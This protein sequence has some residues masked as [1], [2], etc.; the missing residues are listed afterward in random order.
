MLFCHHIERINRQSD[1]ARLASSLCTC[2]YVLLAIGMFGIFSQ[3]A[4]A[5]TVPGIVDPGRIKQRLDLPETEQPQ[6]RT[7][8]IKAPDI[9]APEEA[10]QIVFRLQELNFKGVSVYKKQELLPFYQQY[11]GEKI[12]LKVIYNVIDEI[13][14]H[15]KRDGYALVS[16][17]I[18]DQDF[19][20]GIIDV[21]IVEGYVSEVI[22][23]QSLADTDDG[24]L[25]KQHA[26]VITQERPL[27][28]DTLQRHLLLTNDI[29]GLRVDGA[30]QPARRTPGA[31]DIKVDA[32]RDSFE[33]F[34]SIDN[35]GPE[36]LG[37]VQFQVG[38]EYHSLF[39][40]GDTSQIKLGGTPDLDTLRY[41]FLNHSHI[42][43]ASGLRLGADL[44]Y[45]ETRPDIAGLEGLEGEA[46]IASLNSRYPIM[47]SMHRNVFV[48][49]SFDYLD[50]NNAFLEREL[51]SDGL[52]SLRTG[53]FYSQR[54]SWGGDNIVNVSI[55]QGLDIMGAEAGSRPA[56]RVDYTKSSFFLKRLQRFDS[57]FSAVISAEGQY[58]FSSLLSPEEFG[59]GGREFGRAFRPSEI[60]ADHGIA[61]G[62]ELRY[63]QPGPGMLRSYEPYLF[64]DAGKVW[65]RDD[66]FLISQASGASAGGGLR[67]TISDY[68]TIE[69]EA[70]SVIHRSNSAIGD[71]DW[72]FLVRLTGGSG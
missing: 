32:K 16:A 26:R 39:R 24:S 22:L 42:V 56:G 53:V 40:M 55:S 8:K 14:G 60:T 71:D 29:P 5:Q 9:V 51:S 47:R 17:L 25:V 50:S 44:G 63:H 61:A 30:F 20:S 34:G 13:I 10:A 3:A 41:I 69:M 62:F 43:N 38:A 11:L 37:P 58:A 65:R 68:F 72:R 67:L 33:T 36:E 59:Y 46:R 21:R 7:P 23:P 66:R 31:V 15:Y 54:D 35:H 70:A 18:T 4:F 19:S 1:I 52:R 6:P 64:A 57:G 28:V 2:L 45:I 27:K 48:Y 49:G 12:S